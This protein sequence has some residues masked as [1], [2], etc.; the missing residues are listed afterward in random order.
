M[1]ELGGAGGDSGSLH[2]SRAE[3]D[4]DLLVEIDEID[5]ESLAEAVLSLLKDQ[6]RL[7]RERLGSFRDGH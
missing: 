6:L 1:T 7:D 3:I 5:L 2:V 4:E